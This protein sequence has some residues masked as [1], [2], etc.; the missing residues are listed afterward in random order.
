M[1][2]TKLIVPGSGLRLSRQ[3]SITAIVLLR[4]R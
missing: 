4:N 3:F 2:P 1:S